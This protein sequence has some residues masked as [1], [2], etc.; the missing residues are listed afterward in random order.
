MTRLNA[1]LGRTTD[2]LSAFFLLLAVM[3]AG[4]GPLAA[5]ADAASQSSTDLDNR[6]HRSTPIIIKQQFLVAET[7]DAK[8]MP[9]DGGEPKAFLQSTNF[10]PANV[11][12]GR[13][14]DTE[15]AGFIPRATSSGFQAR[16]PPFQS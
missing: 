3:L 16:A 4:Q 10:G 7:R 1:Y 9:W 5:Q 15:L 11:S 6:G 13:L 14:D 8:A 12:A 2:M